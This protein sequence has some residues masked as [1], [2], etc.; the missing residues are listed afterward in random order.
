MKPSPSNIQELYLESLE[1]LGINPLEHDIRFVEDNW[2]THQ[3]VQLVSV[4]KC[5][6]MVWKSLSSLISNKLVD[7]QLA[8]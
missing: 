8:L 5:G 2:E 4:G 7:W 1:K 6:L 3:L